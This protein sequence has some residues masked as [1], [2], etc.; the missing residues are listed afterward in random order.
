MTLFDRSAIPFHKTLYP[1]S[2][3]SKPDSLAFPRDRASLMKDSTGSSRTTSDT[4][5][6]RTSDVTRPTPAPTSRAL[7]RL[8]SDGGAETLRNGDG[9]VDSSGSRSR[10]KRRDPRESTRGSDC[11]QDFST[12]VR[13]RGMR[14]ESPPFQIHLDVMLADGKVASNE[15]DQARHRSLRA[16]WPS[17]GYLLQ[18]LELDWLKTLFIVDLLL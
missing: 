18:G 6:R 7:K 3:I 1:L 12:E 8:V 15:A 9:T 5:G 11:H 14:S 13:R 10:R 16:E 4:R 17:I 2:L